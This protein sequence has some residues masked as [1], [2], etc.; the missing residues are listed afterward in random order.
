MITAAPHPS[1]TIAELMCVVRRRASRREATLE[2]LKLS[3]GQAAPSVTGL[4]LCKSEV[5]PVK[6]RGAI[7]FQVTTVGALADL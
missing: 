3:R 7:F 5:A 4:L 1:T 2:D 6:Q